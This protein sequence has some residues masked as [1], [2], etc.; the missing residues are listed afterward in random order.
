MFYGHIN[1]VSDFELDLT[2]NYGK[3]YHYP[4]H[5]PKDQMIGIQDVISSSHSTPSH[6]Q[7]NVKEFVPSSQSLRVQP[8]ERKINMDKSF[9][10]GKVKQRVEEIAPR[11]SAYDVLKD[12][13][14]LSKISAIPDR[15]SKGLGRL[16]LFQ[17][18]LPQRVT[19]YRIE[20]DNYINSQYNSN[21]PNVRITNNRATD[22]FREPL[23]VPANRLS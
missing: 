5:K 3:D 9:R 7:F 12:Y 4:T 21:E 6:S 1:E 2:H 10:E 13:A 18:E 22:T 23:H 20:D 17:D 8:E 11:A 15:T 16:S 19:N 14:R